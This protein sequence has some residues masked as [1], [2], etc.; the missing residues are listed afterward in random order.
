MKVKIFSKGG[1]LFGKSNTA[2]RLEDDINSWLENHPE[3]KVFEIKQSSCGGSMEP[4]QHLIS[5]WYE[6][7]A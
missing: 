5:V 7:V 4:G 2:V 6:T 1:K 3:L